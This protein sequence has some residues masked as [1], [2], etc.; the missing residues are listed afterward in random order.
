M[1]KLEYVTLSSFVLALVV[2]WLETPHAS[3][4]APVSCNEQASTSTGSDTT[5]RG[6][7]VEALGD[8]GTIDQSIADG[9]GEDRVLGFGIRLDRPHDP[10]AHNGGR[11]QDDNRSGTW[12][13]VL[14]SSEFLPMRREPI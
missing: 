5:A 2:V 8:R 12:E 13:D 10:A 14:I 6:P 4:A 11:S 1:R 7:A 3:T 9:I